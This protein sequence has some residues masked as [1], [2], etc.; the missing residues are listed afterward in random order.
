M[1]L[2]HLS[3]NCIN[4]KK[5]TIM[6]KNYFMPATKVVTVNV[7]DICEVQISSKSTEDPGGNTEEAPLF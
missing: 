5:F 1:F 3:F 2:T 6:K 7:K 4:T